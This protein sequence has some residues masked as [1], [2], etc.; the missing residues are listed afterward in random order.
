MG[1]GPGQDPKLEEERRWLSRMDTLDS[2]LWDRLEPEEDD[3]GLWR[4]SREEDRPSPNR[5]E[6]GTKR[7]GVKEGKK[8][9]KKKRIKQKEKKHEV[10]YRDGIWRRH[11]QGSEQCQHTR[12]GVRDIFINVS[13]K[14]NLCRRHSKSFRE[15]C[16]WVCKCR[17]TSLQ[18]NQSHSMWLRQGKTRSAKKLPCRGSVASMSVH[19]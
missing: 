19:L 15:A 11:S 5:E 1:E 3:P 10:R 6:N 16:R 12:G 4:E 18:T 8:K 7:K 2:R 9:G 13:K 17:T 14:H